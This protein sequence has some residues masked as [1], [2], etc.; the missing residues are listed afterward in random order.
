MRDPCELMHDIFG[1]TDNDKAILEVFSNEFEFFH[2]KA[3]RNAS[4]GEKLK[5]ARTIAFVIKKIKAIEEL[6]KQ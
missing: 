6:S 3:I 4:G 1:L 5:F 2:G